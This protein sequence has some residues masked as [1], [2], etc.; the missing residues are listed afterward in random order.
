M[1]LAETVIA[2]DDSGGDNGADV[3]RHEHVRHV[4]AARRTGGR[5]GGGGRCDPAG[6]D[7]GRAGHGAGGGGG[8]TCCWRLVA[9]RSPS[10]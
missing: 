6:G 4:G 9:S 7:A 10:R 3:T 1:L 2:V 8:A 5:G